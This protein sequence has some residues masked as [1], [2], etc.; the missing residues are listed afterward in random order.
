M[1]DELGFILP[2]IRIM[3]SLSLGPNEYLISIRNNPVATGNVYPGR[4][5]VPASQFAAKAAGSEPPI[6]NPKYRR[7]AIPMV[8]GEPMRSSVSSTHSGS[9]DNAGKGSSN[10]VSAASAS[11]EGATL[12]F[13]RFSR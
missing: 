4:Y 3:D 1:T 11:A 2:N 12:R 8:A 13:S 10:S 6:T 9:I 7:P 5:M